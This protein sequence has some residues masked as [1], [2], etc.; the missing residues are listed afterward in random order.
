MTIGKYND[1]Q[2]ATIDRMV[3]WIFENDACNICQEIDKKPCGAD[4]PTLGCR[5]PLP[6]KIKRY[7]VDAANEL[8]K[9]RDTELGILRHHKMSKTVAE[10]L[11]AK[12]RDRFNCFIRNEYL[13]GLSDI[14]DS[15]TEEDV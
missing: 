14:I 1:Q 12:I 9:Q 4:V 15:L 3:V 11:K 8:I 7:F 5:K 13:R 10:E 6:D 2:D